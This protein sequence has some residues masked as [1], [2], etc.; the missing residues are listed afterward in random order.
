MILT[1]LF[2]LTVFAAEVPT[3][4][5]GRDNGWGEGNN[6]G[7]TQRDW[8]WYDICQG[9]RMYFE[10]E[11]GQVISTV[12]DILWSDPD[13]IKRYGK[14]TTLKASIATKY[15]LYSDVA[16]YLP[17]LQPPVVNGQAWGQELDAWFEQNGGTV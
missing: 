13:N 10:D 1:V 17:G 5:D 6:T 14:F 4:E 16:S 3:D 8:G 15:V 9:Y 2:G 12:I 7:L 11:N